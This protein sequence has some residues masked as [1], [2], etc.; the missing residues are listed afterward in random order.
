MNHKIHESLVHL[1]LPVDKLVGLENN[2]RHGNVSAIAAS[3]DEFGQMKPIVVTPN[4]DGT[5]TII[6]GN[7]QALA[8]RTLGWTHIAAVQMDEEWTKAVAFALTDNR[9]TDLGGTDNEMLGEMLGSV[10][11]VFPELF[12]AVGWDDFEFASIETAMGTVSDVGMGAASG[13]VAPSLVSQP[14]GDFSPPTQTSSS[15]ES[16]FVMPEGTDQPST[17]NS[18]MATLSPQ[19][20]T[21]QASYQYTLVFDNA[22][23]MKD[24]WEF[25]RSL[26]AS[27]AYDGETIGAKLMEYID[28]H[29]LP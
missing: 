16:R 8:V 29:A 28:A 15:G 1:A 17:I 13:Y 2:P 24:W 6:A 18:G 14:V 20:G 26:R 10:I 3:Y 19:I 21:R 27:A 12:D 7:H 23:Q 9:V 25:L 22:D 4:E 5:Y 11:T